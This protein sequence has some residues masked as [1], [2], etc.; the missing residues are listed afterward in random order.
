MP[1]LAT[2]NAAPPQRSPISLEQARLLRPA[3]CDAFV[4]GRMRFLAEN[5]ELRLPLHGLTVM[6]FACGVG[7]D[8]S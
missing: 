4:E 2:A 6:D 3:E 1:T 7:D 8:S 5:L